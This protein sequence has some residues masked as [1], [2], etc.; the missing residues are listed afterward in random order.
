MI[1]KLSAYLIVAE[2]CATNICLVNEAHQA[3]YDRLQEAF[4]GDPIKY[5]SIFPALND[6]E[7][8]KGFW[9][10]CAFRRARLAAAAASQCLQGPDLH[11]Y[12]RA[13]E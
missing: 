2:R 3:T 4:I 11:L 13:K 6:A 5:A 12:P 1:D 9:R 10:Q 8:K 7:V